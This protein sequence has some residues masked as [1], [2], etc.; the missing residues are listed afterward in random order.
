M[1]MIDSRKADSFEKYL[2]EMA[3]DDIQ[4]RHQLINQELQD[5]PKVT[6]S[7]EQRQETLF[8][9]TSAIPLT[10]NLQTSSSDSND[11]AQDEGD[12]DDDDCGDIGSSSHAIDEGSTRINKK[13]LESD[14]EQK[15]HISPLLLPSNVILDEPTINDYD[16]YRRVKETTTATCVEVPTDRAA[17]QTSLNLQSIQ[18]RSYSTANLRPTITNETQG[19]LLKLKER[20]RDFERLEDDQRLI[21]FG[22]LNEDR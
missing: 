15:Q 4:A 22:V 21:G 5:Y 9:P 8:E 6:L 11:K 16:S 14:C 7:D 12:E 13:Y 17:F 19:P 18:A 2:G 1:E 20:P 3:L 10:I